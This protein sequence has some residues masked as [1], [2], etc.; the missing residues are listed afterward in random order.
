MP[1]ISASALR[2]RGARR[3]VPGLLAVVASTGVLGMV[4]LAAAAPS[5]PVWTATPRQTLAPY[6]VE[7]SRLAAQGGNATADPGPAAASARVSARVYLAGRDPGALAA[8][9]ASV[10][11]P[12]SRLFH[13]YLTPAQV[14]ERFGP[15]GSQVSAIRSWLSA[16]GLRIT[17]VTGHYIAVSGTA[18]GARRAFGVGWHSYKV[19][20]L[21]QQAPAPAARLTAPAR[22]AP[23]V[24]TVAPV[25]TGLPGY[26]AVASP[27][28]SAHTAAL[29]AGAASTAAP[30]AAGP[31]LGAAPAANPG[32]SSYFGQDLASSLPKAYGRVV[33]YFV[34][35][36]TPGQ[37]RSA[38]G[39]P[40]S[41]TGAGVTVAVVHP[42]RQPTAA[43]D[44]AIYGA[45]HGEPLRPG[46]FTQILPAGLDASC[47]RTTQGPFPLANEETA[48]I[49]LV[50]ATAPAAKIVYVGAKCDDGEGTVQDLD[51]LATIVDH[52][53]ATIVS[54]SWA[55]VG[56]DATLSPGLV[57]AYE[58]VF[59]QGAAEGIGF[60]FSAGD[61]GKYSGGTASGGPAGGGPTL[62]YPQSDPWVTSVGGTSLA[63]G[64]TGS[65]QWEAGWG[66]RVA[67][68][69][70]NGKS[71]AGLPGA[72][73]TGSGGGT[74][75]LFSQPSYQR[76]VV[77]AALSKARSNVP[78][79][80][81]PD[82]AADADLATG[83]LIGETINSGT[84]QPPAYIEQTGG[85]TS[86]SCPLIAGMQADAQQAA[87]GAPIG[88]AN[89]AIY[90]R[91]G[92]PAYH[93][94]TDRPRGT[95][96][97]LAVAVPPDLYAP[98]AI[99]VTLGTDLGLAAAPGYDDVTGVGTPTARYFASYRRD[100]H[101]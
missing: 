20:G 56:T 59:E 96:Y 41:L 18:A 62:I 71:W 27:A 42:W 45:R 32:C 19:D 37:V 24:L 61:G 26:P 89:P 69:A 100:S 66:D 90:G 84:S 39:V 25:E 3:V 44:L 8:Y 5:R 1:W 76:G 13:H 63:I 54:N 78:M 31:R 7:W 17:A 53:L 9:A 87:G 92:T 60:Y 38:Y 93:D 52:R 75:T 85:G 58:Q 88:F 2:S 16:S 95:A 57:G 72:F 6:V 29:A 47:A 77:P 64:Q 94:V 34:C 101:T 30:D 48:D 81:V 28:A 36:Y 35:G 73:F 46:Q 51:A 15:D 33:P 99:L 82:I 50:H 40:R 23:A 21:I 80:V 55:A 65:Y 97:P 10:S 98:S 91:Y 12:G 43:H 67:M 74:S 79:R 86:T 22:V 70:A 49:E 83:V 68:P 11:R 4:P 14:R